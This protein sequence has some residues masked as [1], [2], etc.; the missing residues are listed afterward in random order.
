M[1][2]TN[3]KKEQA[4]TLRDYLETV[5]R[6]KNKAALFFL[7]VVISSIIVLKLTPG[8]YTSTSTLMIRRGRDNVV[9]DPTTA[10][11][12]MLPIYKEWTS[13]INSE[14]EILR[15]RE[16]VEAVVEHLGPQTILAASKADQNKERTQMNKALRAVEKELQINAQERSDIV[17]VSYTAPRPELAQQVV[18]LLIDSYFEKRIDVRRTPGA[19]QFFTEQKEQLLQELQETEQAIRDIKEKAEILSLEDIRETLQDTIATIQTQQLTLQ[20]SLAAANARVD[21]LQSV[22]SQQTADTKTQNGALLD[23]D[24][25][26]ELQAELRGEKTAQAALIAES[27]EISRQL[28]QQCEQL[29]DLDKIEP[30]IRSLQREQAL[31]EEKYHQYSENQEQARIN[32]ALE[33]EKISNVSIVQHATLPT[34]P[35]PSSKMFKLLAAAFLGLAGALGIAFGADYMDPTLHSAADISERLHLHT[36]IELPNMRSREL[37]P[38]APFPDQ[39]GRLSIFGKILNKNAKDYFQELCFK[40]LALRTDEKSTPLVIGITS[41]STGEGVSTI[42]AN[43]AAAFSRDERFNN[44]LLL[45]ANPEPS[46]AE[47]TEE[48]TPFTYQHIHTPIEDDGVEAKPASATAFVDYLIQME[49]KQHDIIVVDIPPVSEGGYVVRVAAAMDILILT[50]EAGRTPWRT[51][52]WAAE[53][54]TDVKTV[55]GGIILNRQR[56]AMPE[57]LYRKL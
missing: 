25:R 21:T 3:A 14:L 19:Y 11:G 52:L 35:D 57:W 2:N 15:S 54:L 49:K 37:H 34:K 1:L 20:A 36:L 24:E 48:A 7:A 12:A 45:D 23:R 29:A 33:T 5:F 38:C 13:E 16:L 30:S 6:H 44:P 31:L 17:A 51:V 32:R 8:S 47:W 41:S 56:F 26:K 46:S 40:I 28:A 55:L 18:T 39:P 50:V 4:R 27:R 43:L 42:A 10:T 9:L 53:L 22:L